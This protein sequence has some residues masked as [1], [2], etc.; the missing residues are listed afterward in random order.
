MEK[1][2]RRKKG[3]RK[4]GV[5]YLECPTFSPFFYSSY[6]IIFWLWYPGSSISLNLTNSCFI[7]PCLSLM[8]IHVGSALCL[9]C[10]LGYQCTRRI[11]PDPCPQGYYCTGK[12]GY[13]TMPCPN[14]TYGDRQYL[15]NVAECT[16]CVG[17]SYCGGTALDKVSGPCKAGE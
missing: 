16:Q 2:E 12:T 6:F 9:D 10:P 5:P 11:Q 4:E 13:D 17:G 14:G 15:K 8:L 3:G 1:E 7:H